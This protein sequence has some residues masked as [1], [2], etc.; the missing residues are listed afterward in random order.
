MRYLSADSFH[1][2]GVHTA[3]PIAQVNRIRSL[4]C[5][6]AIF[7]NALKQLVASF[8]S[9]SVSASACVRVLNSSYLEAAKPARTVT[10]Q[11][12]QVMY[13]VVPYHP[14]FVKSNFGGFLKAFSHRWQCELHHEF[15]VQEL[16]VSYASCTK[17][18][19]T[20]TRSEQGI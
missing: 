10:S 19:L 12:S 6:E 18:L 11:Q 9:S 15:G 2:V 14:S 5:T 16:R 8:G 13:I 1:P 17:N 3:W 20:F 4:S 7:R